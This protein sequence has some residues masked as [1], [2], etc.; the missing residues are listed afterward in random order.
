MS[1]GVCMA[2]WL[3]WE[4]MRLEINCITVLKLNRCYILSRILVT[5]QECLVLPSMWWQIVSMCQSHVHW[6]AGNCPILRF[7]WQNKG[8]D[9]V[10][11]RRTSSC[12]LPVH[13]FHRQ[14]SIGTSHVGDHMLLGQQWVI[15]C[16]ILWLFVIMSPTIMYLC[17]SHIP[18][19]I[20]MH[21]WH[22]TIIVNMYAHLVQGM[23]C[24][25]LC[26][27]PSSLFCHH[28]P[29]AEFTLSALILLCCSGH[30]QVRNFEANLGLLVSYLI[31]FH[32]GPWHA[33]K[34]NP[35]D[36]L[37]HC[38]IHVL[39]IVH[40]PEPTQEHRSITMDCIS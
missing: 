6:L 33:Y 26:L 13:E 35:C 32:C 15:D 11:C 20:S 28:S 1:E 23:S 16:W 21:G 38:P 24:H 18:C 9:Q 7:G 19:H 36:D 5:E 17:I 39:H 10:S 31:L 12:C 27:L 37:C 40:I 3:S 2:L 4:K 8:L 22:C 34:D 30:W 29:S 14:H 25:H